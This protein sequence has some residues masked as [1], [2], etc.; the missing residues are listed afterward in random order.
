VAWSF[1]WF[2]HNVTSWLAISRYWTLDWVIKSKGFDIEV[3]LNHQVGKRG[4]ETV[5]VPI[6]YRERL[7]EAKLKMKY[8]ASFLKENS[9]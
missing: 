2:R 1:G 8:G 6:E 5:E 4:F 9:I 3:E 7:S